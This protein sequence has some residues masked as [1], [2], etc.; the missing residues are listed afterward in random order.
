MT[1]YRI[2]PNVIVKKRN[3]PIGLEA[4]ISFSLARSS[5]VFG[6]SLTN[7]I[8]DTCKHVVKTVKFTIPCNCPLFNALLLTSH[9]LNKTVEMALLRVKAELLTVVNMAYDAPSLPPNIQGI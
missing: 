6:K 5:F 7:K 2:L 9:I 4:V 3:P 8:P 1:A